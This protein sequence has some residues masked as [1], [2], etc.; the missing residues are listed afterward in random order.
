[1][2][3]K[4]HPKSALEICTNGKQSTSPR[5]WEQGEEESWWSKKFRH[6]LRHGGGGYASEAE[7]YLKLQ[8]TFWKLKQWRSSSDM[9]SGEGGQ[10]SFLP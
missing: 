4:V 9:A 7:E 8:V 5:S 1:M 3:Q 10:L 6:C 2:D